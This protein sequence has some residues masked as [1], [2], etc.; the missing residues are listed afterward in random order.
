MFRATSLLSPVVDVFVKHFSIVSS[1]Q[2]GVVVDNTLVDSNLHTERGKEGNVMLKNQRQ[3]AMKVTEVRT[4]NLSHS[5]QYNAPFAAST[6]SGRSAPSIML[7][8]VVPVSDRYPYLNCPVWVVGLVVWVVK[9]G[10]V[11]VLEG[12]SSTDALVGVEVQALGHQVQ[13]LRRR[14]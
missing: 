11:R 10:N 8:G 2:L 5:L 9:L 3:R 14:A 12:V 7:I 13:S 1:R 6:G 4:P